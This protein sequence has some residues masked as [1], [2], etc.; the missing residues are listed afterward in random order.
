MEK[1]LRTPRSDW[2]ILVDKPTESR[3]TLLE[4]I[5]NCCMLHPIM[6]LY[7]DETENEQYFIVAGLLTASKEQVA[8]AYKRFKKHIKGFAMPA[9]YKA[10][11]FT[12][13]KSHWLDNE[14]QS[15]KRKMLETICNMDDIQ[16]LYVAY[17]KDNQTFDQKNKESIYIKHLSSIVSSIESPVSVT[18]DAFGKKDFED[19]IVFTVGRLA[20]AEGIA[21]AD[22]QIEPGL[23]FIDNICSVIRLHITADQR[24]RYYEMIAPFITEL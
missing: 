6:V 22:S 1:K 20:N 14:Y 5:S 19:R 24:D 13:F 2:N 23:Q 3:Y 18:F 10:K 11:V 12:E 21:P 7:I 15:I 4:L 8:T 16:I 17:R 9:K